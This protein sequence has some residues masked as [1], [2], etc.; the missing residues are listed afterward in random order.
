M[1]ALLTG[2]ALGMGG[3]LHC[4]AMC[5]PLMLTLGCRVAASRVDRVWHSALYQL[6]RVLTYMVLGLAT[7]LVGQALATQGLGRAVA[8]S[9]GVL[10]LVAAVRSVRTLSF[11][12]LERLGASAARR[13]SAAAGRWSLAHPVS[14][15]L[16]TG[17]AN[18]LLPCG[19][20]YA[21]LTAAAASGD[22]RD[23]A[24]LMAGFGIGTLPALAALMLSAT[25]LPPLWRAR[26]R[27]V[28]PIVLALA[29][30]LMVMRGIAPAHA[31]AHAH[32]PAATS[33]HSGH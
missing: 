9:A 1:T 25:S 14:G 31:G 23:A 29:G 4:V 18:G 30:L 22:A 20:V 3:S 6:G 10:L 5:G 8:I 13:A 11:G 33:M 16:F 12:P 21:A 32:E 7:G 24:V 27:H 2:F 28:T 19:L 17:A 26:L 15:P